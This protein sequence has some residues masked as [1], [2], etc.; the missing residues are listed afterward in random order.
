MIAFEVD[1]ATCTRCGACVR[2]CPSRIIV[3]RDGAMPMVPPEDEASCLQCQH[4]LAV[5]PTAAVSILGRDPAASI[6]L[7]AGSFP[8]L[9]S[10]STLI[11]GR[12]SVRQYRDEN[13]DPALIQRLLTAVANAPSGCNHMGLTFAVVDDKAAMQRLRLKTYGLLEAAIQAGRVPERMAF[14]THAVPAWNTHG[15]DM[16]YRGAPHLLIVSTDAETVCPQEDVSLALATFELLA[17]CAGL[18]TVWCGILK[19]AC[20]LLPEL[21]QE[22]GLDA[23]QS[24]YAMLF[25][26]PAVHYARTVQRDSAA[27]V[28]HIGRAETR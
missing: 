11:R 25:G 7:R 6:P 5:C 28:R 1:S 16:V 4:C 24:Y 23:G 26:H 21:K 9:E 22:V 3:M 18:G 14:L 10:M 12:R 20:E 2:D 8:M 19:M 17:A 15:A 27:R 13:V